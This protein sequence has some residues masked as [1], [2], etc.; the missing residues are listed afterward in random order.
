MLEPEICM[1]YN[2]RQ[3]RMKFNTV[4]AGLGKGKLIVGSRMKIWNTLLASALLLGVSISAQATEQN[5]TALKQAI[6][7]KLPLEISDIG[8]APVA[9]LVQIVTDRGLFYT[10]ADGDFLIQGRIFNL[11]EGMRNE[12]EVA[13]TKLRLDGMQKF[14]PDTIEFK[15]KDEKYVVDVFT[16]ITCGYC[17]KLHSQI[18][19]YNEDGITVRYLAFPRGGLDSKTYKDMVSVWCADDPKEALTE[20]KGGSGVTAK[21][22]ENT[23]AAQYNFGQQVGV[24]GTPA[25]MLP[26]GSMIPG[27]QPPAQLKNILSSM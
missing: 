5:Y 10:S 15:A 14:A 8:P 3:S 11:A 4:L 6:Q 24:T 22:C 20:A 9:G 7:S 13:L 17:R 27:Y 18:A 1:A 16:D 19:A 26:D 23:V 2:A 12:T 21:T 25:I